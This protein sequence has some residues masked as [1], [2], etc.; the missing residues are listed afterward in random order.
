[1]SLQKIFVGMVVSYLFHHI[2]DSRIRE[3]MFKKARAF[4]D[5]RKKP[6]LNIGPGDYYSQYWGDINVDIRKRNVPNLVI[7]DVQK[8][9]PFPDKFFG[10][11]Y[12]SHVLEHLE[13]PEA[14]IAEM[15]RVSEKTFIV[16]PHSLWSALHPDH[17]WHFPTNDL[18]KRVKID[19]RYNLLAFLCLS[20]IAM[21]LTK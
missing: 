6:L 12:C 5:E 14:A 18:S 9:L 19:G 3:E 20:T 15:C 7:A 8:K 21:V 13:N 10:A 1:M 11:V 4:A 17:K 16:I 2:K